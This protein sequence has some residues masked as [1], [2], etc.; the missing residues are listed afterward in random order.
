MSM[1]AYLFFGLFGQHPEPV[2]DHVQHRSEVGQT[3]EDPEPHQRSVPRAVLDPPI[4]AWSEG[5]ETH[6]HRLHLNTDG[7]VLTLYNTGGRYLMSSVDKTGVKES[8]H[9]INSH[10]FYPLSPVPFSNFYRANRAYLFI[11]DAIL[12]HRNT[13]LPQINST[14]L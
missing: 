11:N 4:S 2:T 14:I 6:T 5:T 9:E 8:P 1:A 7:T 12:Q 10:H 3:A 13:I